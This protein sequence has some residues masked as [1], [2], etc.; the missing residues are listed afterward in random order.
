MGEQSR[1]DR[2]TPQPAET[3]G[4]PSTSRVTGGRRRF[5]RFTMLGPGFVAAVAYL[6]PG[7][8]A[9]NI[10]AGATYGYLLV[11]VIVGA[12][13]MA[14]LIQYLA[15]RIGVLTGRT[16]P[17]LIAEHSSNPVRLGYWLQAQ[18]VAIAT[19]LAEV[20]GGALALQVL[21]G[22]PLL[23][24]AAITIC[25]SMVILMLQGERRQRQFERVIIAMVLIIAG[26]ILWDLL[27]AQPSLSGT[28]SGLT[29]RFTGA[30]S[31]VLAAGMLGA[32]VMPHAIYLHSALVRDRFGRVMDEASV[33]NLLRATRL[34]I[35]LSMLVA[36]AVN[37][38]MVLLAAGA[39]RGSA[40]TDTLTG[41]H[42]ALLAGLGPGAA[43][44]FAVSLLMAGLASTTVG[45]YS[46]SVIL[47]G[48]LRVNAS[49]LIAR[50]ITAVPALIVLA[51]GVDATRALV[52]SQ[53]VLSFGIP[54]VLIPLVGL[55]AREGI[56]GRSLPLSV[57][58]L[59]W[60]CVTLIVA[61]NVALLIA[62]FRG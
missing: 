17:E 44:A 38:A 20:V 23:L 31:L 61:L 19:D 3:G 15:A 51:C 28:L 30:D 52:L 1:A 10:T 33:N 42:S 47:N 12:N 29:P 57:R 25:A 56:A 55:S 37:L 24:G 6:D 43:A 4:D 14:M 53:V 49:P 5:S 21:T 11:W 46:G 54:L 18:V 35:V 62:T 2:H 26:G 16:L 27:A 41:A 45:S 34:D 58:I 40:G 8:F 7:N 36:G 59:T 32:T 9:T 48:L 50:L 22:M 39:L 60:I 13:L